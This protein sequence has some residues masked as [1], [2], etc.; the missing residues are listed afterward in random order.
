M[1]RG[2]C[3]HCWCSTKSLSTHRL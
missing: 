3:R 2:S 1:V